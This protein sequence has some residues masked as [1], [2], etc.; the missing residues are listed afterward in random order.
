[1]YFTNISTRILVHF[2]NIFQNTWMVHWSSLS[3][4]RSNNTKKYRTEWETETYPKISWI[5]GK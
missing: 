1:M 4:Q 5:K 3:K 2:Q